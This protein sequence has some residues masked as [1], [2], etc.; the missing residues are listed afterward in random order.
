MGWV[1]YYHSLED[2]VRGSAQVDVGLKDVG[3]PMYLE[4]DMEE[5]VDQGD[6]QIMEEELEDQEEDIEDP[7]IRKEIRRERT[8]EGIKSSNKTTG[9]KPLPERPSFLP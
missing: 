7:T 3:A 5:A 9:N 8:R 4:E 6:V 2:S 1:V